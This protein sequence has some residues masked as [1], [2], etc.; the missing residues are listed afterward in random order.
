LIRENVDFE[1][2]IFGAFPLGTGNDFAKNLGWRE[3]SLFE[4][5]FADLHSFVAEVQEAEI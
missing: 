3:Y 5:N 2:V 1:R 4:N